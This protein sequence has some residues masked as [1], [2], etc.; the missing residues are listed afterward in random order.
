MKLTI[1][2]MPALRASRKERVNANFN[3]LA[4]MHVEQ[5]HAQKRL[6]AATQDD[7]L[8]PEADLR[9]ITVAELSAMILAKPDV[10]AERELRRQ[11]IM[12]AIEAAKTPAE[13]D[14]I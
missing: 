10:V 4:N 14:S 7:R 13:L 12:M 8:K 6:W 11:R 1:D 9:G 3:S 5:A 2:P